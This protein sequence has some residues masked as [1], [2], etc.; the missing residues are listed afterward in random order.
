MCP[1]HENHLIK[2]Q[3]ITNKKGEKAS[4]N[5]KDPRNTSSLESPA[6][7]ESGMA[8]AREGLTEAGE[9]RCS[10]QPTTLER[11]SEKEKLELFALESLSSGLTSNRIVM[12]R[13][14]TVDLRRLG[15][16][17]HGGER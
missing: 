16:G 7:G 5:R 6:R 2:K 17:A 15:G 4:R 3:S 14:S 1:A 11:L 9:V 12:N 8:Q 10:P 13:R